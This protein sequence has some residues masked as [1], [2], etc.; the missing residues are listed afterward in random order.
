MPIFLEIN[1][2]GEKTKHGIDYN[3]ASEVI[4]R[5]KI[6][7]NI[8]LDGLMTMAPYTNDKNLI[9]QT[10]RKLRQ[11][12]DRYKLKTSMGMSS[13]WQIAIEEGSDILRIGSIIF[14]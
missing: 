9:R 11:L 1:I 14:L 8:K 5:V 3:N 6:M 13:D 7:P 4:E 10:F 2:S 12:A